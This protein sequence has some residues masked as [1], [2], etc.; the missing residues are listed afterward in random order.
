MTLTERKEMISKDLQ[1][2]IHL[3]E[4]LRKRAE[5]RLKTREVDW[6][7]R[8]NIWLYCINDLYDDVERWF[9]DY[10]EE[11]FMVFDRSKEKTIS[12]KDIET[13]TI[14]ILEIDIEGDIIVFEPIGTNVVGAFGRID[15]YLR[16]HKADQVM[17][18]LTYQED[19][20]VKSKQWTLLFEKYH[21]DFNKARFEELLL[22][23]FDEWS[24]EI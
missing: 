22:M 13:Y 19:N 1:P 4:T 23:W 9:P 7:K 16:G 20:Y 8:K 5:Q 2:A 14:H 3:K 18:L 15:V 6:D 10:K 21:F 11:G 17:L 12:E 24:D